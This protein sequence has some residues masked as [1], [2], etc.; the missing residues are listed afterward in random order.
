MF[1]FVNRLTFVSFFVHRRKKIIDSEGNH[2]AFAGGQ[3]VFRF[4]VHVWVFAWKLVQLSLRWLALLRFRLFSYEI[5][6]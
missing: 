1:A 2:L 5:K 3:I 4:L 6:L